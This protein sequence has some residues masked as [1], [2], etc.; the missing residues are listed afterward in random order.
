MGKIMGDLIKQKRKVKKEIEDGKEQ[1]AMDERV[2]VY[3]RRPRRHR[4]L[5]DQRKSTYPEK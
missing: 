2:E 4:P 3:L 1:W 5:N